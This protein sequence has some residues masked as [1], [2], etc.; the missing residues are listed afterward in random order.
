MAV[1]LLFVIHLLIC[2]FA[3]LGMRSG[4]FQSSTLLMVLVVLVPLWGFLCLCV[5]EWRTRGNQEVREEVG[6]EKMRIND[7][8]YRSILM[9]DDN[10]R[11][12]VVPLQEALLVNQPKQR[13]ELMMDVMYSGADS[14]VDQ[15]KEARMNDDTEVVHYAITALVEIQKEFD[16]KFQKLDREYEEDPTNSGLLFEYLDL[17]EEYLASGVLEGNMREVQERRYSELLEKAIERRPESRAFY[18]KK[19]RTDLRLGE[20]D[21]A[22]RYAGKMMERWPENEAG[23]LL[24]IQYYAVVGDRDGIQKILDSFCEGQVYLSAEGRSTVQFWKDEK[25]RKQ[26]S[27]EGSE[28]KINVN[29]I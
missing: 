22:L 12:T 21:G 16:L 9:D 19:I 23:Y 2:L 17:L 28:G 25:E 15:L 1:I 7:E 6:I 20:Y 3:Y 27:N 10:A 29:P 8:I 24:M 11:D 4:F 13:R 14:Y 26:E 18:E 5:L